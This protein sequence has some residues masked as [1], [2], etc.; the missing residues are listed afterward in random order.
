MN[1]SEA[2][3]KTRK[4]EL[5]GYIDLSVNFTQD[6]FAKFAFFFWIFNG[7]HIIAKLYTLK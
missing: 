7:F 5:W 6:T 1:W 4:C 3:S 2:Y